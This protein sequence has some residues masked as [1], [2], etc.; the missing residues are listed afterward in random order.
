MKD[1]ID[2]NYLRLIPFRFPNLKSFTLGINSKVKSLPSLLGNHLEE[3]ILLDITSLKKIEFIKFLKNSK[4]LN[5]LVIK[6]VNL[7][8]EL[9]EMNAN[10][11]EDIIREMKFDQ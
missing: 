10:T 6:Y 8:G 2:E 7:K 3:L 1:C 11:R 5:K 4:H 9:K